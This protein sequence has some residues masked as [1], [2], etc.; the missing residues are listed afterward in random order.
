MSGANWWTR[1]V[2]SE[3]SETDFRSRCGKLTYVFDFI[4]SI[5]GHLSRLGRCAVVIAGRCHLVV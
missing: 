1:I 5:E 4:C 2:E 3:H